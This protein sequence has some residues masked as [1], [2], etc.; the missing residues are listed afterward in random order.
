MMWI[1]L[2]LSW[3]LLIPFRPSSES[4]PVF[5]IVRCHL[6]SCCTIPAVRVWLVSWR[7]NNSYPWLLEDLRFLSQDLTT[8]SAH[9]SVGFLCS[10]I[11]S[12][13]ITVSERYVLQ[14][15]PSSGTPSFCSKVVPCSSGRHYYFSLQEFSF[16]SQ[17]LKTQA[18]E[19]GFVLGVFSKY[20]YT[21]RETRERCFPSPW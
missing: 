9:V 12:R 8:S 4:I 5:I 11:L 1:C 13:M 20:T 10:L 16:I 21:Y 14:E 6:Y 15:N 17:I 3:W 7:A 19:L 18:E 2:R